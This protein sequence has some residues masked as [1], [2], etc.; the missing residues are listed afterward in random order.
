VKRTPGIHLEEKTFKVQAPDLV[1]HH[2]VESGLF[3]KT[4]SFGG[5]TSMLPFT[6]YHSVVRLVESSG[7]NLGMHLGHIDGI[8]PHTGY[9]LQ[10]V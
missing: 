5:C 9:D 3:I 8:E 2:S 7:E 1:G 6:S 10:T 4:W